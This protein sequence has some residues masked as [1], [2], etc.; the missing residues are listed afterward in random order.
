[1]AFAEPPDPDLLQVLQ[2]Q[3][4]TSSDIN[5]LRRSTLGLPQLFTEISASAAFGGSVYS[6]AS[7]YTDTTGRLCIG[8]SNPI[9]GKRYKLQEAIG[10]GTFS[11]VFRTT[12]SYSVKSLAIKVMNVGFH[13]L[14]TREA[15]F[16]RYFN[17]KQLR[18]AQHCK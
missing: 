16:L 3:Y 4:E 9:L 15:A 18:G 10:E 1:M 7:C 5:L 17:G 12:D 14:G 13:V 11:Q 8:T 2:Q 6:T